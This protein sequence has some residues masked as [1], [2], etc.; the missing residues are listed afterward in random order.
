[1]QKDFIYN[2]FV[3]KQKQIINSL[4][5]KKPE[6]RPDAAALKAELEEWAQMFIAQKAVRQ[7]N[8]TV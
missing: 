5:C 2:V 3:F 4:L 6:D 8:Q 1:M 7:E